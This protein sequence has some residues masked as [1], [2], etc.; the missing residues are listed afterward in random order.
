MLTAANLLL[1]GFVEGEG[2]SVTPVGGT[3]ASADASATNSVT[4][5]LA[6]GD[7]TAD[8]GTN[9]ANYV[10]PTVASGAGVISQASLTG[11]VITG[12]PTKTYDGTTAAIL[13]GANFLLTGFAAGE[14]ATVSA[15]SGT[16]ATANASASNTVTVN[17]S[18]GDFTAV[19]ATN[20]GNYVLPSVI[21]GEGA[22]DA[23]VLS[24]SIIGTP[25]KVYDGTTVADLTAANFLL[26]GFVTGEGATVGTA[27]GTYA[28]ADAAAANSVTAALAVSDFAADKGTNLANYVLPTTVSGTGA[29]TQAT[30]TGSIIATPTKVY[31]GSTAAVLTAANFSLAGFVTG[32]GATVSQFAGTYASADAAAEIAVTASLAST[33]FVAASSTNLANYILP[34]TVTGFGAITQA[35]LTGSIT[36]TPTKVYDGTTTATLTAANFLLTGFVGGE[37]ATVTQ[38]TGAY[39]SANASNANLVTV[40]LAPSNFAAAGGTNLA[41]YVLPTSVS[42]LGVISQAVLS[43]AVIGVPTKIYDGTT[44]AVLTTANFLLTGFISG[45]GATIGQTAGTYASADASAANTVTATLAAADFAAGSGTNLANYVLPTSVSGTGAITQATLTGTVVGTP[46]KVYDGTTVATLTAANFLL[47]GFVTGEGATVGQTAGV[48]ASANAGTAN[49]VTVTLAAGDFAATGATNL[50]NYVLPTAVSGTGAIDQA[51]LSASIVGLPSKAFDGTTIATLTS[52]NFNLSGFVIGEGASI[53][54]TQGTYA[55][56]A[57]GDGIPVTAQLSASDYAANSGTLLANYILPTTASGLGR[58]G[59]APPPLPPPP[60]TRGLDSFPT[61]TLGAPSGPAPGLELISTETT[62]RILDE[63]RA[64]SAFCKALVHQEYVID[65]LS[66][67][68]QSVADGL[69][70]VGE[71]SEVRAALED[72]AQQLHALALANASADLERSIA[73]ASGNRRSSRPLT[74]VSAERLGAVNAQAAAIINGA[75]L[76]L[77]RSSSGSA[78]RSVAFSQVA[79]VVNSTKVL[80]RSS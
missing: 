60:I 78:R 58:I 32:E 52:A 74:A 72:A 44:A 10:L 42:G 35:T 28:S 48:Y 63:I 61:T 23:A 12:T 6:A 39:A 37:S 64:G 13:T 27:V 45:E 25:T 69:S 17:L 21:S 43:G 3:Y 56:A 46:T 33:D 51:V 30:I 62:Q 11:S 31:D 68:L 53:T 18:L 7:F 26:T 67:R 59:N 54:Q 80:L 15:V 20:L 1:S 47:S 22:I 29:I 73:R 55:T 5:T 14:G 66:D 38:T 16:Y 2:A 34:T 19:G 76:V 75:E 71:Y 8:S 9:L 49:A 57:V 50:A 36:G 65:C 70:A 77:L 4:V 41:N 79:Q 40:T 24:G